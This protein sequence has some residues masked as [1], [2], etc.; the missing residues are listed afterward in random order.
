MQMALLPWV[1]R[2]P[3]CTVQQSPWGTA[4]TRGCARDG[5]T[6]INGMVA[7]L[8]QYFPTCPCL[9]DQGA[10]GLLWHFANARQQHLCC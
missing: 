5:V 8:G 7:R 4:V 3:A 10:H 6:L 9:G 1:S 2:S